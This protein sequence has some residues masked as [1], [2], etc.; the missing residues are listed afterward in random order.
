VC[1]SS[2]RYL[3]YTRSRM[4]KLGPA[5]VNQRRRELFDYR[6]I[7]NVPVTMIPLCHIATYAN[8]CTHPTI[9]ILFAFPLWE[10][11]CLG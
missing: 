1:P 10:L 6:T 5:R 4:L 9:S 2:W 8:S 3:G 11:S 7:G